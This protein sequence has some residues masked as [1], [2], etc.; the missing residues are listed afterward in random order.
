MGLLISKETGR[1]WGSWDVGAG[2]RSGS[3]GDSIR[4]YLLQSLRLSSIPATCVT[5]RKWLNLWASTSLPLNFGLFPLILSIVR[6]ELNSASKYAWCLSFLRHGS[7]S[8]ESSCEQ[9]KWSKSLPPWKPPSAKRQWVNKWDGQICRRARQDKGKEEASHGGRRQ[10]GEDFL[11]H[12]AHVAPLRS[13]HFTANYR[14][15]W[16]QGFNCREQKH[17][18]YKGKVL[19][20]AKSKFLEAKR[21]KRWKRTDKICKELKVT[22]CRTK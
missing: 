14:A 21:M 3:T 9:Q 16:M 11:R 10:A 7:E 2:G 12:R 19:Y 13:W 15:K 17:K 22:S 4:I 5:L 8:Y 6:I 20:A 18:N 1:R